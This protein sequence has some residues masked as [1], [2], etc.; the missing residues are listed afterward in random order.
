V[1]DVGDRNELCFC[2]VATPAGLRDAVV[3]ALSEL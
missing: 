2:L 1:Y 3:R